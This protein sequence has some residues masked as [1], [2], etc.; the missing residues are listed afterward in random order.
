[1]SLGSISPFSSGSGRAL[2]S[3]IHTDGWRAYDGL[4]DL[5]YEK[6]YRVQHGDNE[7]VRQGSNH[8]NGI[9]SWAFA[10]LRLSRFKGLPKYTFYLY[11]KETEFRFNNRRE[12]I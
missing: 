3:V 5:G 12:D 10:K 6:H 2:D 8:I 11:L 1:M 7:F 4:V 9:E